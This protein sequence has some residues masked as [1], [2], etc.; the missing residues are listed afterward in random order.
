[1]V[2]KLC[3]YSDF[4]TSSKP[5]SP[6]VKVFLRL[7][8]LL[9]CG[10]SP[11]WVSPV[12]WASP[13]RWSDRSR[14][15]RPPGSEA[16][17]SGSPRLLRRP[18]PD[19]ADRRRRSQHVQRKLNLRQRFFFTWSCFPQTTCRGAVIRCRCSCSEWRDFSPTI[20][21]NTKQIS[22]LQELNH[23]KQ[24]FWWMIK[25][26]QKADVLEILWG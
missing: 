21:L 10:W 13:R 6:P 4:I 11:S 17:P 24:T 14:P 23:G 22:Y 7:V 5:S 18:E 15:G 12:F 20:S 8:S 25:K 1:M 9:H 19:G 26:L 2:S 16:A 3:T